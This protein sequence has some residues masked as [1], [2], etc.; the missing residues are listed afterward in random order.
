MTTAS[1]SESRRIVENAGTG[2][3]YFSSNSSKVN[4]A[5]PGRVGESQG[6]SGL[7]TKT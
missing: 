3:W 6:I 5:R 1:E 7:S 4:M 2:P